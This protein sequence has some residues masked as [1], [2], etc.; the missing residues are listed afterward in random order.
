MAWKSNVNKVR[1]GDTILDFD[2]QIPNEQEAIDLINESGGTVVRI[3][4]PHMPPNP[5]NFKHINYVTS[6]G[7]KGTIQIQKSGD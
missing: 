5:H 4:E 2:G 7:K 3:E 1:E 6:T